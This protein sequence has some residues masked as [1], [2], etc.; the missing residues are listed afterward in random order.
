[1]KK[2][3]MNDMIKEKIMNLKESDQ[4]KSFLLEVIETELSNLTMNK[5]HYTKEYSDAAAKLSTI[6]KI[7]AKEDD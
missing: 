2:H 7:S 4:M 3:E 5:G 1:M 6:E